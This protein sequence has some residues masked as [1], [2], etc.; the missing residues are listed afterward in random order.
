MLDHSVLEIGR[1][2]SSN[3]GKKGGTRQPHD[4]HTRLVDSANAANWTNICKPDGVVVLGG[5]SRRTLPASRGEELPPLTQPYLTRAKFRQTFHKFQAATSTCALDNRD[6]YQNSV[7]AQTINAD[8]VIIYCWD[9]S[10]S[11]HCRHVCPSSQHLGESRQT[12][13]ANRSLH[14]R[15]RP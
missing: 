9:Q 11:V 7:H 2:I 12:I 15:P 3:R 5:I 8:T 4:H 13:S 10:L 6:Q 14:M 1:N